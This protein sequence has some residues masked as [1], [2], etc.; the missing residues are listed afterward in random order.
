MLS[1]HTPIVAY[2]LSKKR[3]ALFDQSFS[4][5]DNYL[6]NLIIHV[7]EVNKRL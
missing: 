5:I 4:L 7:Y 1:L 3:A 6:A 2:S